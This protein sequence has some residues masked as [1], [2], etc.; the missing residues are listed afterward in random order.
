VAPFGLLG[1]IVATENP[2]PAS[3]AVGAIAI[4]LMPL[5]HNAIA[6]L[7]LPVF[8]AVVVV[9]SVT[10]QHWL[11]TA[12]AGASVILGGLALSAFFWLPALTEKGYVK[13]DLLRTG[14]LN[15]S[16]YIIYPFQLI[17]SPWGFGYSIRGPM[18]GISY[19][20][21]LVHIVLAIAGLMVGVRAASRTRR[22]DALVYA[23]AAIIGAWLATDWSWAI[24]EHVTTLQYLAYPWRAL[25]V[26]ALFMPLLAVYA[27]ERAGA[28]TSMVLIALIVLAN[29]HHTQ[30]KDYLTYDDEYYYPASIAR[31]GLNTTTRE[32]YE[33]HWVKTRLAY[34]GNS[35]V[36]SDPKT[37]VRVLSWNST[38]HAYSVE[39][40]SKVEAFDSTNYYPGWTVL[41]DGHETNVT[42]ASEIGIISFEIPSGLHTVAIELR[43]T[44]ARQLALMISLLTLGLLMLAVIVAYVRPIIASATL[45]RAPD[46]VPG[47]RAVDQEQARF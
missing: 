5:A 7:M 17:W 28:K 23:G 2:T 41:I 1:L 33:P 18:N 15:W 35:L 31:K 10:S 43:P 22:F 32:E 38:G 12:A 36:A 13:T 21:G 30:P 4:A 40:P 46:L 19:S 20:L 11:R 16:N 27:F 37:K 6:L 45:A 3:I 25:C 24:W 9:R 47:G 8:A 44:K 34:T 26:P 42:P 39:A 14:F 29:L